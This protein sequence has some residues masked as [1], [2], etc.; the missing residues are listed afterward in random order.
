[1]KINSAPG[2]FILILL[3]S[4]YFSCVNEPDVLTLITPDQTPMPQRQI[5]Y[6]IEDYKGRDVG[7]EKPDWVTI[8][9]S[10]GLHGIES[11]EIYQYDYVFI[12]R[13][14]GSNFTALNQWRENFSPELDFPH[15]A[16][17]RIEERFLMEF[18]L[19]DFELGSFY[20]ALIRSASDSEWPRSTR[21]DDFWMLIKSS[22]D[23]EARW[24][25]LI[26]S[27][28]P[29]NDFRNHFLYLYNNVNPHTAPNWEQQRAIN[30][31]RQSFFM[32]F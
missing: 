26:L 12:S 16:A 20:M 24:E 30:R 2:A 6:S 22:P 28:I 4:L 21:E 8:Y 32:G 1:M 5:Y 14:E 18:P 29:R 27:A 13:N 15:L 23:A 11:M 7:E 31:F 19:P 9:L 17:S 10:E 25:F 3:I